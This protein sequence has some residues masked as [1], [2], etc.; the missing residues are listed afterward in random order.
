MS[1]PTFTDRPFSCRVNGGQRS[2]V[3]EIA[4]QYKYVKRAKLFGVKEVAPEDEF[5]WNLLMTGP[6]NSPYRKGVFSI[7]I[8]FP[9]DYPYSPPSICF[10]T[11]I[12]HPNVFDD[13][14]LCWHDNDTTG[15]KYFAD[16]IIGAINTLLEEP[17]P[18]S[19]AN[20]EAAEL[21][22]RNRKAFN[23]RVAEMLEN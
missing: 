17:N 12:F 20:G 11:P 3:Q 2:A 16:I 22:T 9:Q 10:N 23:K 15:S 14:S 4:L 18:D 1:L 19:P 8:K 5:T 13:G 7:T 21:F 6:R